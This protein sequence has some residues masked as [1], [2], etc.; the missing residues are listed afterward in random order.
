MKF[1]V[2]VV[3]MGL[4]GGSLAKAV[5]KYTDYNVFGIDLDG[6]VLSE[7]LNCGAADKTGLV[8]KGDADDLLALSDLVIVALS[9]DGT[10]DFLRANAGKIKKGAIVTDVCGVKRFVVEALENLGLNFIGGHP[11]AGKTHNGFENSDGQLFSGA[12]YILTP[13]ASCRPETVN[14]MTGF[15][16]K[17]GSARVELTSP[18]HHDTM[19][20]FTSQLPHVL[21]GA[22][23]K[24]PAAEQHRGY[25]AGSFRDVS[26]VATIDERLWSK[27]FF[28]NKDN[29]S[30]EI[31]RLIEHLKEYKMAVDN[32]DLDETERIIKNG[33]EI[34]ENLK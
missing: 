20:A 26:R 27:L 29:L 22:Y 7:A 24:S 14:F 23:V 12:S 9:P 28:Y 32:G 1:N 19:I 17:I 34:K 10:V 4:I 21:A 6:G 2:C 16:R 15:A 3:G 25:S 30:E 18:E 13:T 11:M 33:R 8:G 5:K 31:D